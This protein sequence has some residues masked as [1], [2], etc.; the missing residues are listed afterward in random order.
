MYTLTFEALHEY[1]AGLPGITVPVELSA[2]DASVK[3]TAKLDSGSTYCVFRR[4]RGEALGF[5][6][7]SGVPQWISTATGSFLTYGHNVTLS[8]LGF[9]LDVMV[10]FAV[11]EWYNRDV[12]GRYGFRQQLNLGVVDY[13]GKLYIGRYTA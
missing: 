2:G 8:G 7:E 6:I 9:A 11:D 12:L 3:V 10:Y 13:E 1:D 5:D 4:A